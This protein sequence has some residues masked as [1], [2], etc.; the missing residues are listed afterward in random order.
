MFQVYHRKTLD[1][2]ISM[3]KTNSDVHD[4]NTRQAKQFHLPQPKNDLRKTSLHYR[5][6]IIWNKI[7]SLGIRVNVSK[8]VFCEDLKKFITDTISHF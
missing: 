6:S 2:F 3:F 5:G 1:V 4:H 7:M 8:M